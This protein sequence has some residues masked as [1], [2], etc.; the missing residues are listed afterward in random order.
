MSAISKAEY[1][2]ALYRTKFDAFAE[3]AFSV[4]NPNVPFEWNWHIGCIAEHLEAMYNG[5]I[6]RL[7]INLPPRSLKS[8]LVS[9][10]FPAYVMGRKPS[11]KFINTSYG[12]N[13]V[14]QNARNCR[15][16]MG[17]E[18][19]KTVYPATKINPSMDRILQFETMQ[20][21]QFYADTAL[22]TITGIGCEYMVIDDPIKPLEAFS[23]TVRK[24]TNQNVRATLLNRFDDRR[25]AKLLIVMQRV[26]EDDT[27]GDLQKDGGFVVVKLPAEAKSQVLITLKDKSWKMEAGDLL[28]PKR[29][30]RKELD[31]IRLDMTE[32]HYVGQY[33]QEPVP[34]GGGEFKEEWVQFYGQGAIKPKT[35]NICILVD[36]SGGDELNKK[37]RKASDWTAMMVVGLAPDNNY[38]LLDIIRDRLN[39]TERIDTLFTLHRKWN[40]L[41]GKSPKVG[42]EQYSMQSD[43]HYI[44][45]KMDL[46][47]YRFPLIEIGG[48]V[49]KE[50]RIRELI[51]DMQQGRWYFPQNLVYVDNEGRRFD[52]VQ[53]IIK[54]EM[55]N[56][57]RARF[58]DCIDALSRIYNEDLG[59][60]FPKQKIGQVEKARRAAITEREEAPSW[61]TF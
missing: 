13:V 9:T 61:E 37:K 57:P 58:D 35:M 50:E 3:R 59:M 30:D 27:T 60:I 7:I 47:T 18:W 33:L 22:S 25:I 12:L 14:E 10:A 28:F 51:P 26:H 41:S 34:V 1:A 5:E 23:D 2:L 40:E 29:L 24:T 36:P 49:M 31:K 53:E 32:L 43:I 15:M 44:K 56:F 20:R 52:L 16:I 46:E 19:Y 54:S 42:Y 39:P 55:A 11:A 4:V 8:Y 17:S 6:P 45:K 38:Y 48:R 21:G